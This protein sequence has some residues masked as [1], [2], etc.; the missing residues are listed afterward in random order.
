MRRLQAPLAV[1]CI[2]L[3]MGG[4]ALAE[5]AVRIEPPTGGMGWLTRP[6]QRPGIPPID[7]NNSGRLESLVRAGNLYVSAQ[8]VIEKPVKGGLVAPRHLRLRGRGQRE[9]GVGQK[10]KQ[11]YGASEGDPARAQPPPG[12]P[13]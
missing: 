7:M 12:H 1:L 13:E 11:G 6:Y 3:L 9:V 8:D 4:S 2:F 5:N 10:S